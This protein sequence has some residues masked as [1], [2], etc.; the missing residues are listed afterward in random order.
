MLLLLLAALQDDPLQSSSKAMARVVE[1]LRPCVVSVRTAPG[2]RT[3]VDFFRN[4][5]QVKEARKPDAGG[6][7]VVYAEGLVLTNYH[8]VEGASAV[9]VAQDDRTWAAKLVGVDPLTDLALLRVPGLPLKPA[10]IGDSEA[11]RVGEWVVALGDPYIFERSV[12]FGIVSAKGR[13]GVGLATYEEFLQ[14]DCAINPGNSGGLLAD[15]KGTIVGINIGYYSEANAFTGVGFAIPIHQAKA[16]AKMLEKEGRARYGSLGVEVQDFEGVR[17]TDS[18]TPEFEPGDHIRAVNGRAVAKVGEFL[19]AVRSLAPGT[20]AQVKR[21]RDATE[22]EVKVSVVEQSIPDFGADSWTDP[23][24][25]LSVQELTPW[26]AK[27][28]GMSGERGVIV[29]RTDA[30]AMPELSVGDVIVRVGKKRVVAVAEFRRAM[31]AEEPGDLYV[32]S[33]TRHKFVSVK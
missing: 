11:L 2:L 6:S 26:L 27:E 25:G 28:L 30:E 9:S 18:A 14:V 3:S 20:K 10:P 23:G 5:G 7:G 4:R 12:T 17:V 32:R 8:V 21:I 16:V 29:S 1:K 24:I 19:S 13:S 33:G 31:E 15:M 22:T